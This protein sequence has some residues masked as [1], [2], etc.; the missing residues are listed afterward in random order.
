MGVEAQEEKIVW[1]RERI[2]IIDGPGG[3]GSWPPWRS[4][5]RRGRSFSSPPAKLSSPKE[6]SASPSSSAFPPPWMSAL[7]TSRIALSGRGAMNAQQARGGLPGGSNRRGRE[8]SQDSMQ[9]GQ[10]GAISSLQHR[11]K[12]SNKRNGKNGGVNQSGQLGAKSAPGG[13]N[14]LLPHNSARAPALLPSGARCACTRPHSSHTAGLTRCLF[15]ARWLCRAPLVEKSR[16]QSW[17]CHAGCGSTCK[18]WAGVGGAR[19]RGHVRHSMRQQGK[20]CA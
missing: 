12:E 13:L 1:P 9:H 20:R 5:P 11:V 18:R 15:C 17:Q 16:L 10:S 6:G 7:S 3:P 19:G 2:P 4:H 14:E 8:A